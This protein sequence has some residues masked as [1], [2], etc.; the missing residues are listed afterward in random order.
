[1]TQSPASKSDRLVHLDV[2]RGLAVLGLLFARFPAK[3][4]SSLVLEHPDI[5]G[6]SAGEQGIW[7]FNSVMVDDAMRGLFALLFGVSLWMMTGPREDRSLVPTWTGYLARTAGLF[8]FG[9][10]FHVILLAEASDILH[11]YALAACV[12]LILSRL[13]ARLLVLGGIGGFVL[14][15]AHD[16]MGD[17][18]TAPVTP[19]AL[20]QAA[21]AHEAGYFAHIAQSI[22]DFQSW[23]LSTGIVWKCLEAGSY[24]LLGLGLFRIG[25]FTKLSNETLALTTAATYGIGLA[26]CGGVAISLAAGGF[27]E[28]VKA[29]FLTTLGKPFIVIGHAAIIM[30]LMRGRFMN[31]VLSGILAPVGRMAL[32]LY[33]AG[34]AMALFAFT[35]A[36][37]GLGPFDRYEITGLAAL[38]SVGLILGARAW[39][40]AFNQGP[41]EWA[42]RVWSQTSG[43]FLVSILPGMRLQNA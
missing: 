20:A 31:I 22:R 12:A 28:S 23:S 39:L 36:G 35:G 40:S 26:V 32:T 41:F 27:M 30:L 24:M 34:S 3:G 29:H 25:F 18:S 9:L 15:A 7:L 16:F 37:L 13:D 17:I 21:S 11:V 6:W 10:V 8:V 1:M 33:L 43:R 4:G 19:E 14:L 5:L 38:G 2:L 42:L